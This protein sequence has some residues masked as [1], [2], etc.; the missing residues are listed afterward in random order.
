MVRFTD[1][2]KNVREKKGTVTMDTVAAK[3]ASS[4]SVVIEEPKVSP[5]ARAIYEEG[6]ALAKEVCASGISLDIKAC[7]SMV[8]K[9][10]VCARKDKVGLLLLAGEDY[11]AADSGFLP[12]HAL[13]TSIISLIIGIDKNLQDDK[14]IELGV[15]ALAHDIGMAGFA[16]VAGK[17][18]KLSKQEYLQVKNHPVASAVV[19]EEKQFPESV[20]M[21]VRQHHER[22]NGTGYPQGVKRDAL[23]DQA[24][25]LGLVDSY[26]ALT[27]ERPHR[28][29]FVHFDAIKNL[30]ENKT[31]F[32]Y[33]DIKILIEKIGLFPVGSFVELSTKETAQVVALNPGVPTRPIVKIALNGTG[34]PK[35]IDLS[36]DPTISIQRGVKRSN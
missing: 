6:L 30:I 14:L 26:E 11:P 8:E 22:A 28:Q 21:A 1:I 12:R 9:L 3:S 2:L 35:F 34:K 5:D 7:S 24:L 10:L 18:A 4:V 25:L 33:A 23:H 29:A 15:A 36:K 20:V 19:L 13:N 16:P 27:H 32:E 17:S 31:A